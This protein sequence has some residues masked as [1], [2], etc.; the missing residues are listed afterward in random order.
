MQPIFILASTSA[1]RKSLLEGA[2]LHLTVLPARIDEDTILAAL[3]ADGATPRDIADT[4]A[5]MKAR[6]IADKHP[7]A[8]VLGCDQVL[9]LGDALLM[10]PK[11]PTHAAEQLYQMQGRSHDLFSA[12]VLYENAKPIWRHIGR[13]RLTM[14][15]MTDAEIQ[16]YVTQNWHSIQ[17]A[18]GCY[19]IEDGGVALF[20]AIKGDVSTIQGLPMPPLLDYLR[21]RGF[22]S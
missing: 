20:S 19:K 6:K 11:S 16:T 22:I 15:P 5:E 9:A 21:L 1:I 4:L 13:A 18:V 7:N 3:Q 8:R 17:H 12:V 2:G 10:K 14:H